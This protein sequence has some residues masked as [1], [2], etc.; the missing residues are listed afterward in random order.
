MTIEA[1]IAAQL[2]ER[3]DLLTK[4][5]AIII[6]EDTTVI[7]SI[8][9]MMG[10]EMIIYNAPGTFKYGLSSVKQYM[11][12]H[13]LPMYGSEKIYTK[14]KALLPKAAFQKGCINF[15]NEEE[16]PLKIVQQLIKDCAKID[17]RAIR[18]EYLKSK[19]NK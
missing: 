11:S 2:P 14:Y 10:K 15:K 3:Q 18:E 16:L 13:V 5:N 1:F 12:L 19:K 17:L 8:A 9:P 6:K 4:V 7:A